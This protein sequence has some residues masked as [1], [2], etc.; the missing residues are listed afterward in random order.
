MPRGDP[1]PR[2]SPAPLAEVPAS[3][4]YR[5]TSGRLAEHMAAM[6][7]SN[8]RPI[9]EGPDPQGIIASPSSKEGSV[10]RTVINVVLVAGMLAGSIWAYNKYRA[11]NRRW[12]R[13]S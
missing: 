11:Y 10:R 2:L 12:Q 6:L 3:G 7:P 13:E 9:G 8:A 1:D 4:F 5:K